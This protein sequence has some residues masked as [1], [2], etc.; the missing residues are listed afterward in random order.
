MP[1]REP[2]AS[3][4]MSN[5]MM[6]DRAL[7]IA[8]PWIDLILSGEKIWEMRAH[9]TDIRGKVGLIEK[10]TGMI[11]GEVDIV[12]CG[13]PLSGD[14]L[15]ITMDCHKVTDWK[16]LETWRYPW[17]LENPLRYSTPISY[18]HPKGAVIWVRL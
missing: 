13:R 12:G 2:T 4:Y 7:I 1:F 6:L 11:V 3:H 15:P 9:P 10:G 16:L 8:K 14:E 5:K 18:N 17:F